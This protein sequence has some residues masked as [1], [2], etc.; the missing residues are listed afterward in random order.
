MRS[1]A[2][3]SPAYAAVIAVLAGVLVFL[4]AAAQHSLFGAAAP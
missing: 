4:I 3:K 2:E 1:S